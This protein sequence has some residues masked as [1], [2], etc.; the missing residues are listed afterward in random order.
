MFNQ[1]SWSDPGRCDKKELYG[2]LTLAGKE[3]DRLKEGFIGCNRSEDQRLCS[4]SINALNL[5]P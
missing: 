4:L 1:L 3:K 5:F 2:D